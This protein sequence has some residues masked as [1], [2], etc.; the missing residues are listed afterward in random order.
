MS[1]PYEGED[2]DDHVD[3]VT[4][5]AIQQEVDDRVEAEEEAKRRAAGYSAELLSLQ[6][7]LIEGQRAGMRLSSPSLN[8]YQHETPEHAE[9][10]RGRAA[11]I[12]G[13]HN[14]NRRVA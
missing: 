11:V 6:E 14:P 5:E 9:W 3:R 1:R 8:P 4:D 10:E 12:S 13:Y 7:A 2:F